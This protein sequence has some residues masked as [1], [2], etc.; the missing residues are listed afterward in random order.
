[1]NRLKIASLSLIASL[2]IAGCGG[3][4]GGDTTASADIQTGYFVDAPVANLDYNTSSGQ[5]DIT[6]AYGRFSYKKGETVTFSIG[7]LLLGSCTPDVD[8]FLATPAKLTDNN[9]TLTLMLQL[10]QSLDVDNNV[11]NGIV[12]PDNVVTSLNED[13]NTTSISD[14]NETDLLNIEPVATKIDTNNDR[15]IDINA[16]TA[17]AHFHESLN[18]WREQNRFGNIDTNQTTTSQSSN[19]FNLSNYPLSTLSQELKDALAHMGNEERLAH[20]IYLNLY[21]YHKNN[22]IDIMQLTNIATRSEANHISIVQSLVDR[23]SLGK[24]DLTNIDTDIVDQ[25]GAKDLPMGVYDIPTI[26]DLYDA[27]YAKGIQSQKDALEV[28]CMVEVTDINDLDNYITIAQESNATDVEE[29]FK[30]LR[31]GS[32]SHY[33]A[34]DTGLKNIGVSNGCCS[35]GVIDGVNYCHDEYPQGSSSNGSSFGRKG[36]ASTSN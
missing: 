11:S 30:V 2:M 6:D 21:N 13:I 36:R 32:Y 22:G 26:Q 19:Y 28:G 18:Q 8:G 15:V 4:G 33:W 5:R 31:E 25:Y 29:A 27:L 1:M 14:M 9:E 35:L 24:N 7:K 17:L 34:F 23:Y 10:L 12:I 16:S 3:G 20:D